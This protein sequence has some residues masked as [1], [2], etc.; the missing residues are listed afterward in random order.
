M[1]QAIKNSNYIIVSNSQWHFIVI[2]FWSYLQ[3]KIPPALS[4]ETC[5]LRQ[6]IFW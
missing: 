5:L 4:C 2:Y 6:I 1:V 3:I